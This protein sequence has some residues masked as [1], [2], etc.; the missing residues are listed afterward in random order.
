MNF[1]VGQKVVC[2]KSHSMGLYKKG[3]VFTVQVVRKEKCC[4]V[5]TINIGVKTHYYI[6]T[7]SLCR[8]DY[9][10]EDYYVSS[11]F[12]PLQEEKGDKFIEDFL[13]ET[14]EI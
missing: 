1:Y 14:V 7:C 5:V 4:G 11:S 9:R 10:D 13:T 2:V 3:Q 12:R 8:T 6:M